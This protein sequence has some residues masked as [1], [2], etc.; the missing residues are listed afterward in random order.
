M[1]I[2]GLKDGTLD[3]IATDHAPHAVEDKE[4][5][6]QYA[7]FGIIGLE[8]AL[9][10]IWTHLIEKRKLTLKQLILN[11]SVNPRKILQLPDNKIEKG[12]L[13][14]L[15]LIDPNIH[16]TVDSAVFESKSI[17][18]PFQGRE[19]KG[20]AVGVINQGKWVFTD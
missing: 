10:L 2:Q 13:A 14:N 6:F 9:G 7:A 1:L 12:A 11:M 18:T 5:E 16:W 8:T 3:A 15:T 17:N 19:L 4:C 20:K